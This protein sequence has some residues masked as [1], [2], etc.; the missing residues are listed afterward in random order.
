MKLVPH[1]PA[2]HTGVS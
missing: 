2:S 1:T